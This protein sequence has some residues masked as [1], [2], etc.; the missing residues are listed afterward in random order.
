[1]FL[2]EIYEVC[3]APFMGAFSLRFM[4]D[5]DHTSSVQCAF[6]FDPDISKFNALTISRFEDEWVF[7]VHRLQKML[8][9]LFNEQDENTPAFLVTFGGTPPTYP[10]KLVNIDFRDRHLPQDIQNID[11]MKLRVAFDLTRSQIR[12]LVAFITTYWAKVGAL[13]PEPFLTIQSHGTRYKLE[14]TYVSPL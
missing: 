11:D 1:M 3:V 10:F 4:M 12:N 6:I 8:Q 2:R 14:F 13:N 7:I 5:S 9:T